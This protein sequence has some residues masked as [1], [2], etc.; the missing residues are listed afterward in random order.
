MLGGSKLL[1]DKI[2]EFSRPPPSS[3][4]AKSS[5]LSVLVESGGEEEEGEDVEDPIEGAEVRLSGPV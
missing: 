3:S 4:S 5:F 2:F 1:V